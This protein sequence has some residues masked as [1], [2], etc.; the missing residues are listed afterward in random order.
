MRRDTKIVAAFVSAIPVLFLGAGTLC[1]WA[2]ANGASPRWRLPFRMIC[3]GIERRCLTM[4]GVAMPIC[5]RCTGIYIGLFA[6]VI[7]FVVYPIVETRMLRIAMYVAAVPMAIDGITQALRLRESINPLRLATGFVAAFTFGMW[8]LSEI[9][10]YRPEA[11]T[12]S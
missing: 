6:G 12:N 2:V 10:S 1:S 11:V 5:A 8:A 7:A 4:F 3:H 9:E